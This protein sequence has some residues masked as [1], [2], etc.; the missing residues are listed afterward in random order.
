MQ[1][2]IAAMHDLDLAARFADRMLLLDGGRIVADGTPGTL[3]DGE[4]VRRVFGIERRAGAWTLLNPPE[5]PRS[6]R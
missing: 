4:D 3:I 6:S 2:V 1:V 5:D